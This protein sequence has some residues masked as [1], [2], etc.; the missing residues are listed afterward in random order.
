MMKRST[1]ATLIRLAGEDKE[2]A[3]ESLAVAVSGQRQAEATLNTL[4]GYL[5]DYRQGME[6]KACQGAS[7]TELKNQLAFLG[8]LDQM[9]EKQKHAI[10]LSTQQ[11]ELCRDKWRGHFRR[12]KS[13]SLLDRRCET[14]ETAKALKQ[15]QKIL[16]E[17]AMRLH[18]DTQR[19]KNAA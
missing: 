7:A 6:R 12:E 8:Q 5:T 10:H 3:A 11:V 14:V 4:D 15:E 16:D 13:Y 1:L 19:D 18:G 17:H 2:R 9:I